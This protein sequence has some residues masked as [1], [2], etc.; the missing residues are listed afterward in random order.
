MEGPAGG[1]E[2]GLE[3]TGSG[4]VEGG[5]DCEAGVGV[6][7]RQAQGLEE[8]LPSQQE[9][10]AAGSLGPRR[11]GPSGGDG[12]PGAEP[13]QPSE[14]SSELGPLHPGTLAL[15]SFCPDP[16]VLPKV[17]DLCGQEHIS[18]PCLLQPPGKFVNSQHQGLPGPLA[19]ALGFRG[20]VLHLPEMPSPL[21]WSVSFPPVLQV[22]APTSFS[23]GS[24]TGHLKVPCPG[25]YLTPN[26][27]ICIPLK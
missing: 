8:L 16:G 2:L 15:T 10:P 1:Q 4:S 27:L 12:T 17:I 6:G 7:C 3:A 19:P 23:L 14:A 13:A 22:C 11:H 18:T 21:L 5:H 25:I 24:S 9:V 20:L 26:S